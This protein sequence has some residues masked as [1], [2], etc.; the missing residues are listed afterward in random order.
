VSEEQTDHSYIPPRILCTD[1]C[2]CR[3]GTRDC[4]ASYRPPSSCTLCI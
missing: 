3:A 4:Y 2:R 1:K